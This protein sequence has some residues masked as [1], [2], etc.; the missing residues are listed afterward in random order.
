MS[1]FEALA[2]F[3]WEGLKGMLS[4]REAIDIHHLSCRR[5]NKENRM[6]KLLILVVIMIMPFACSKKSTGPEDTPQ[7]QADYYAPM[8]E[9]APVIDGDGG[10]ACWSKAEWANIDKLWLGSPATTSDFQGRYKI[11]WRGTRLYYLVDITDDVLS[12]SYP[13]PL[14][15][16]YNDDC[17]EVFID[18]DKSGGEH[19]YNYNAF[20][21]HIALDFQA[22]DLGPDQQPHNFSSHVEARRASNGNNHTWEIAIEIYTD[23]YNDQQSENPKADLKK[24][25]MIGYAIAYCDSDGGNR[26]NFYGSMDIPGADK[27][28][29]WQDASL[30]GSL[31]LE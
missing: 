15:N 18:E 21:Y 11:V 26:E 17:V 24:G 6:K 4:R 30:F 3:G 7:V 5:L 19:T 13:N 29:A 31:L 16:Y 10:D 1:P 22:I 25:K 8:A 12:D 23:A 27:N 9:T 14:D 20:A 2:R 28:R